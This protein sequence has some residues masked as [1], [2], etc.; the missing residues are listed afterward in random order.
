MTAKTNEKKTDTKDKNPKGGDVKTTGKPQ[1]LQVSEDGKTATLT[2]G[3]GKVVGIIKSVPISM[4]VQGYN[5]R[6]VVTGVDELAEN[7]KAQGLR[8]PIPTRAGKKKDTYEYFGG[9]R[10]LQALGKLGWTEVPIVYFESL[11]GKDA[12]TKAAS[13]A[14]NSDELRI[15]LSPLEVGRT[16]ADLRDKEKWS[17]GKIADSTGLGHQTIRR[18]LELFDAP[19][20]VKELIADGTLSPTAAVQV[21]KADA[22]VQQHVTKT[23]KAQAEAGKDKN[24]EPASGAKV[25]E[26]IAGFAKEERA[27]SMGEK[28][29]KTDNK[30]ANK[31]TGLDR[32]ADLSNYRSRTAIKEMLVDAFAAYFDPETSKTDKHDFEIVICT[33]LYVQ[34]RL[35]GPSIPDANKPEEKAEAAAYAGILEAAK[36]DLDEQAAAK[37]TVKESKADKGGKDKKDGKKDDKKGDGKTNAKASEELHAGADGKK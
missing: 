2:V 16:A 25:R 17:I 4:L 19:K 31:K 28:A 24:A 1:G 37:D 7:I 18:A 29:A 26:M 34:G 22:K 8:T 32:D 36:A 10:R 30:P 3:T 15:N 5:P 27:K 33:L 21:A 23:L 14:D 13:V 35:S 11:N 12:E 6:E 20:A 9:Q